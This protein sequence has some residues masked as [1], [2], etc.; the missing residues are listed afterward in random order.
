MYAYYASAD[1]CLIG[2]SLLPFGG[3]NLIEAMRLGKP[4]LLGPHTYNFAQVS[5]TA[6][7]QCAA[8]RVNNPKEIGLALQALM[9]V[10]EK[11]LAMGAMGLAMCEAGQGASAKTLTHL[12]D[13]LKR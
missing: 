7:A 6:V 9:A 4:V 8:W 1:L 12:A 13:L 3:Q 2:G 5:T 10:P 11:R